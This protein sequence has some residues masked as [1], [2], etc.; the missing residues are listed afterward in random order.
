MIKD[1]CV[2]TGLL[3]KSDVPRLPANQKMAKNSLESL[4]IKFQKNLDLA[5]LCHDQ[6]E[7][8]IILGHTRQLSKEE[9]K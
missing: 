5:E 7:E 3:S 9:A 1:N 6:T 2:E 8:Y 4:E